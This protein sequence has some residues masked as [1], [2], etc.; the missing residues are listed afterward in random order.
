MFTYYIPKFGKKNLKYLKGIYR[1]KKMGNLY[2]QEGTCLNNRLFQ[3]SNI[4]SH[5][6]QI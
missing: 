3:N 6:P 5:I 2:T 4:F 1:Y